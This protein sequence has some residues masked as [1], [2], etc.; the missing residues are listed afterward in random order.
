MDKKEVVKLVFTKHVVPLYSHTITGE[1]YPYDDKWNRINKVDKK[2]RD[3]IYQSFVD[4]PRRMTKEEE[5]K[6]LKT[7]WLDIDSNVWIPE[8]FEIYG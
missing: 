7:G 8:N 6:L 1:R 5:E 4:N 2:E 3:S